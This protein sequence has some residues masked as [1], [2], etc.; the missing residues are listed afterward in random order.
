MESVFETRLKGAE[1]VH[2]GK[3]RDV[4]RVGAR[5][6]RPEA[7][8]LVATDRLS[9][10]D[11]VMGRP[12]PDK[13][14]LLTGISNF[15]TRRFADTV[16]HHLLDEDA[17]GWL[18]DP[19]DRAQVRG[20]AVVCR[21]CRPLPVEAI[22]RGYLAGSGF[23]EYRA[24]GTVCGIPLPAG[25]KHAARLPRPLYTPSTKAA[26]GA[27]DENISPVRAEEILGR[28]TAAR[29]AEL[30]LRLYEAGAAWA[31][32]RGIILA[33]TKFEFGVC[34]GRVVLIDEVLTPDSS[35]FWPAEGWREGDNPPSFD[36][37]YVR[38]WL[39]STG[40]DKRAPAP[41]LPDEVVDR[42]R[43]KYVEAYERITGGAWA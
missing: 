9:A 38:D 29:V 15:W 3:V 7:L 30:S 16:P 34:E 20:R 19:A 1:L 35:R 39:E 18:D 13:G 12:I 5:A 2:R 23:K 32:T 36:K 42:T 6:G 8:L 40:W 10:F 28:D 31:A 41:E 33:D 37:Q 14:R 22:V 26:A 25:L 17:E 24:A 43:A 4:Y 21:V 11:V 27:H